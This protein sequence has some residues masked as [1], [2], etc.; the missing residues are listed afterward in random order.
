MKTTTKGKVVVPSKKTSARKTGRRNNP[1]SRASNKNEKK[2]AKKRSVK[3]PEKG[4]KSALPTRTP[5]ESLKGRKKLQSGSGP[6]QSSKKTPVK[7][8]TSKTAAKTVKKKTAPPKTKA[9]KKTSKKTALP[10]ASPTTKKSSPK[11]KEKT[12][13]KVTVREKTGARKIGGGLVK[14]A[15]PRKR[16]K[17][18]GPAGAQEKKGPS[19]MKKGAIQYNEI[20]LRQLPDEYGENE[21]ILMAVDPNVVF[22]DWEIKREEA[23][24]AKRELT[25]R[26]LDVTI[27]EAVGSHPGGFLDIKI[28]GRVGS[29]FFEIAMPGRDVAVIIGLFEKEKFMPILSSQVVSMPRLLVPD[30]LGIARKLFEAGIPLGY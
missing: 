8:A 14:P 22:V 21:L 29:G 15:A 5:K 9:M 7:K 26:V 3:S 13:E 19:I 4:K 20:P 11:K 10:K 30:E 25:M 27:D 2:P 18:S 6:A 12:P 1:A 17:V 28:E 16:R 23:P 24:Q